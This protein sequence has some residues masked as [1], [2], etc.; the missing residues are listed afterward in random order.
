MPYFSP[1]RVSRTVSLS[2]KSKS[3]KRQG[4]GSLTTSLEEQWSLD[5]LRWSLETLCW[6]LEKLQWSLEKL[7]W[8]Q[9][10]LKWS[11]E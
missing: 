2:T 10:K 8:S 4:L 3:L 1:V 5:E 7:Q 6:S 11:L 9:E